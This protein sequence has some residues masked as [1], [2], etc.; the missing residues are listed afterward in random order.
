MRPSPEKEWEPAFR[1]NAT[2]YSDEYQRV[3]RELQGREIQPEDYELLLSLETR[4]N[5]V[6]LPKFLALAY[7]KAN[8]MP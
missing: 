7:E 6:S 8:P 1:G 5:I 4:A 3:M 2:Q